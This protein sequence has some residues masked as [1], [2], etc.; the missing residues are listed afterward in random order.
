MFPAPVVV[1]EF[2]SEV[3]VGGVEEVHYLVTS[4]KLQVTND[5]G[6]N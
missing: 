6:G 4:Y 5:L 1:V 3:P 2:Q